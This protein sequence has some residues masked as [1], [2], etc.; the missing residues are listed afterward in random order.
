[1]RAQT[2]ADRFLQVQQD[3]RDLAIERLQIIRRPRPRTPSLAP[4]IARQ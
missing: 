1:M 3:E 2:T 4:S